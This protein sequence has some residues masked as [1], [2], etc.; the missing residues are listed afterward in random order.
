MIATPSRS[1][2][3]SWSLRVNSSMERLDIATHTTVAPYVHVIQEI[4]AGETCIVKLN[5]VSSFWAS[6]RFRS[7]SRQR[8]TLSEMLQNVPDRND[9]SKYMFCCLL[10]PSV[11]A[12][13]SQPSKTM[14][15]GL[16]TLDGNPC[17]TLIAGRVP[18]QYGC[19]SCI[20]GSL[21]ARAKKRLLLVCQDQLID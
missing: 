13:N 2:T 21:N 12:W 19:I 16:K 4:R 1:R 6:C 5:T 9:T 18:I 15:S 14:M 17:A 3:G 7:N 8:P 20:L 11:P 10:S